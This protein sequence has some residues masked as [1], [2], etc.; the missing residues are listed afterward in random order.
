MARPLRIEFP[1]ALYHLT[2][3]G[4]ARA[5]IFLDDDDRYR[6]LSLLGEAILKFRWRC[7]AYCLMTNHY[8]LVVETPESNLSRGMRQINGLYTQRFNRTHARVGHVLQ[9]RFHGVLV[10]RETHLLEL[11]RYVV[12]NPVRAGMVTAAEEYP[13]SSLRAVLGLTPSPAWLA[14]DGIRAMFGSRT[15]YLDFVR[16]GVGAPSPWT[17]LRGAVLG[18]DPFVAALGDRLGSIALASEHPRRERL[19]ARESLSA[20]LPVDETYDREVR[21]ARIREVARRPDYTQAEIGRHL[22]LHYSTISRIVAQ[23]RRGSGAMR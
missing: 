19:V 10:E 15:R 21:N 13:W 18:S 7:Y 2:S 20:R 1:G 5:P 22:G 14:L 23:G 9:G 17:G 16:A 3:R 11:A 4:N 12:L 6:F 8:H